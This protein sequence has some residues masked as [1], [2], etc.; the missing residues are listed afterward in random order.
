MVQ[1]FDKPKIAMPSAIAV[2]NDIK[3][4]DNPD[5]ANIGMK[6]GN[7]VL[8]NGTGGGGGMGNGS[9]GGLGS[10]NGIGYGPGSGWNTGGGLAQVGGRVS[11]PV[12]LFQPEAEFSDEARRAKYQG[13][14]LVGLIVDAQGNP[15]NVRMC[16]RSAWA[17]TKKQWKR[18]AN[19][20]SSRPCE[21]VK[22]PSLSTST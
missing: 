18:C 5:L 7:V 13:V 17:S 15:Q 14:C 11:A 2:Q 9:G 4:P 12:P 6:Q 20:S 8:S 21:T 19:T 1:T 22:L 16:A 10:G 3:L